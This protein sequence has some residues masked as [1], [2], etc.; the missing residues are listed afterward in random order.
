MVGTM[1]TSDEAMAIKR[2]NSACALTLLVSLAW[3]GAGFGFAQVQ[4]G[5][6]PVV[7]G[8]K[9]VTVEHIKIHGTSLEGNLE[10]EA[11]DRDVIVFLPPSYFKDRHR[12][13][14]VVYAPLAFIDQYIANLRRYRAISIDAGDQD[15]L[16]FDTVKLH[17]LLDSYGIANGSEIFSGT[18]TSAVAFRF[19]DHVLPFF[20]KNLCGEKGC[21]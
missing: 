9:P 10:G 3:A 15:G 2:M 7:P 8:A 14:P 6:P 19:Q 12:R 17:N 16:R 5:L 1:R 13:Y 21:Q 20:S 18:H 11:V 4:T